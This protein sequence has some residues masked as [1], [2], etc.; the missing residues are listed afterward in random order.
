MRTDIGSSDFSVLIFK[1]NYDNPAQK[2]VIDEGE[3]DG[4]VIDG[5][6]GLENLPEAVFID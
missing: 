4:I 2:V 5:N 3:I 6:L 1:V